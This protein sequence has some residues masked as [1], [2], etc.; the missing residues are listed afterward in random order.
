MLV[1]LKFER[2]RRGLFSGSGSVCCILATLTS[3]HVSFILVLNRVA[4]SHSNSNTC[5]SFTISHS[6][7]CFLIQ[8]SSPRPFR[9]WITG[10]LI[11]ATNK[12]AICSFKSHDAFLQFFAVATYYILVRTF[13]TPSPLRRNTLD[14]LS[15]TSTSA[16]DKWSRPVTWRVQNSLMA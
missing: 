11:S 12:T 7:R 5:R 2:D 13:L 14:A 9:H 10:A 6:I 16:S 1:A 15:F 8:L 4:L 3:S